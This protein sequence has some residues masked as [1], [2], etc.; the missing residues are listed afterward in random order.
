MNPLQQQEEQQEQQEQQEKDP[1]WPK[2]RPTKW[3][4][5][6]LCQCNSKNLRV[7]ALPWFMMLVQIGPL[8]YFV[9]YEWFE[10][11]GKKSDDAT[12]LEVAITIIISILFVLV[13]LNGWMLVTEANTDSVSGMVAQRYNKYGYLTI[14][15]G[16]ATASFS[17]HGTMVHTSCHG[18]VPKT[19]ACTHHGHACCTAR[20]HTTQQAYMCSCFILAGGISMDHVHRYTNSAM[21]ICGA[22]SPL[23]TMLILV[24]LTVTSQKC[25]Q[26]EDDTARPKAV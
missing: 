15:C 3:R 7:I 8:V 24:F 23:V 26:S 11:V 13:A 2:L 10:V 4:C 22:L 1:E 19:R 14:L 5:C 9:G 21:I 25:F 18:C 16:V 6:V 12:V 17:R 20:C